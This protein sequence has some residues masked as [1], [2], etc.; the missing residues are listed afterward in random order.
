MEE[1]IGEE[2]IEEMERLNMKM[3]VAR[4]YRYENC[5]DT[6]VLSHD[7]LNII[8]KVKE[9]MDDSDYMILCS[10]LCILR[11]NPINA[12]EHM[13]LCLDPKHRKYSIYANSNQ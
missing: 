7:A 10:A 1:I 13:E 3:V 2:L 9:H 11:I 4:E 8:D 6:L 5:I 12:I